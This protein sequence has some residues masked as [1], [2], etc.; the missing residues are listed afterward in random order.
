LGIFIIIFMGLYPSYLNLRD[1][2]WEDRVSRA[3]E[4]RK[5]FV[6]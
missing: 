3:L 1:E 4:M 2:E 6:G 5:D